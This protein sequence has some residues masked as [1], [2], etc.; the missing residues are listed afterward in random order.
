MVWRPS[1]I[2]F[3]DGPPPPS[4]E[5]MP[6][7]PSS[8]CGLRRIPLAAKRKGDAVFM[9]GGLF[10]RQE[11]SGPLTFAGGAGAALRAAMRAS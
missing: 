4:G 6:L 2:G 9:T 7:H 11:P 8:P 1:T 5:E 10:P 3:A